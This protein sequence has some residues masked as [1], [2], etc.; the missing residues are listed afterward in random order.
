M[1]IDTQSVYSKLGI[2]TTGSGQAAPQKALGQADF[3]KLMT[4]QLKDQD[5]LKPM[6][7]TAFLG[8][9]AQ[10]SQ[11]QGIQDL[12]KNFSSLSTSMSS[13]SA[14][15][16]AALIGHSVMLNA[17][18][19]TNNGSGISGAVN[20]TGPG[21]VSLDVTNSS[22]VVVRHM[23]TQALGAGSMNY[24][25][26]GKDGNGNAVP[27]GTYHL[28]ANLD[29]GQGSL[30]LQTQV[31]A[32]VESVSLSST[33]LILNLGGVGATPLSSIININ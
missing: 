9:L 7:S 31:N 5:P 15:Q 19:F 21:T 23:V 26:D 13:N 10:F 11:V 6:D 24:G 28:S 12:N 32:P 16:G 18:T 29:T 20:V 2:A 30:A 4:E 1:S 14:L 25:W 17:D 33:G 8:Q 22:G 27:N 3:L